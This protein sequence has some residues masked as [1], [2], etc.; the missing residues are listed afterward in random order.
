MRSHRHWSALALG[1]AAA[2]LGLLGWGSRADAQTITEY[3]V[4]IPAPA[5]IAAGS[6]GALWFAVEPRCTNCP[7][8]GQIGRITT[9]GALV[10]Y[11]VSGPAAYIAAGP[12]GALWF[13]DNQIGRITTSGALEH[14]FAVSGSAPTGITAGPDGA[15]WFGDNGTGAI[16]RITTAGAVTEYA[17][18]NPGCIVFDIGIAAGPDGALWFT[19]QNPISSACVGKIGRI[20]T[21]GVIT[22][23]PIP[24][25]GGSPWRIAAG[26]DGAMWF[27]EESGDKIGRITT[28]GTIT[29]YPTPTAN[30]APSGIAAGPDGALWFTEEGSCIIGSRCS[31]V[32]PS[33]I[34]RITTSG[35]ITEYPTPSPNS[36]PF[37]IV[38]G[39][40]G[41]MWFAELNAIGRISVPASN[42]VLAASVL[43]ESRS[44]QVGATATAFA[45]LINGGTDTA[46]DCTI[47]P[48]TVIPATFV[49]QTTDPTTNALTGTPNT[50]VNIG[51][52]AAQ[53]FVIAFTPT[54]PIAPTNVALI[55]GCA[56]ASP[57]VAIIGV[58]TL[59]LSS[60][61][62]PV[63]DIV[64]VAT[65][66]DPGYVDI[67]GATGT[68]DFAV[69]TV[70]LGSAATIAA[71]A[72]PGTANPPVTLTIC[73]TNPTSGACLAAPAPSVTTDIQA[74]ATPTF[75]IFVTGS[76]AVADSPGVN[77]VFVTFTDRSGTLRG[78][79]SVAVRTH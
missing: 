57:A 61:S 71:A 70:N 25:A 29:E 45:T 54:G 14:F 49:F 50:P 23:Y 13:D 34:G 21:T 42:I 65:S 46:I 15:L 78:E 11:P 19:E 37:D 30:S 51:P 4:S 66:A 55:F 31:L 67:P 76:A 64:A 35:V 26:P 10:E 72:N 12:D 28:T 43:P 41:A 68:G 48:L 16:G 59:A 60:S 63:P 38:A 18:A 52:G 2:M 32:G 74:N 62:G 8:G 69:A 53:T 17:L 44:A 1:V 5:G 22:E 75:G 39:P 20:T 33:Q 77:R 36:Q 3:P 6:D 56:N 27:T 9:A 7:P 47:A 24:T 40:D 58:N 79:T 73:Q